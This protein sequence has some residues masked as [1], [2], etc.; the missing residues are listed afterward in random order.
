MN[1]KSIQNNFP[2]EF[3]ERGEHPS[4]QS[5]RYSFNDIQDEV[6]SESHA[7]TYTETRNLRNART[8]VK[9][10][11][12]H[13]KQTFVDLRPYHSAL[14]GRTWTLVG[15]RGEFTCAGAISETLVRL[16][17]ADL[18]ISVHIIFAW[19]W[20]LDSLRAA[21][22]LLGRFERSSR[23]VCAPHWSASLNGTRSIDEAQCLARRSSGCARETRVR[24]WFISQRPPW[25]DMNFG[26]ALRPSRLCQVGSRGKSS[27]T[28]SSKYP[29]YPWQASHSTKNDF[30]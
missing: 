14:R 30:F 9:C 11:L 18:W 4:R 23:A 22:Y 16:C 15:K 8:S 20:T 28:S 5:K 24:P 6:P 25:P 12:V 2:L 29:K 26:S 21:T 17:S 13:A 1:V 27:S 10:C 3:N 7:R 19:S